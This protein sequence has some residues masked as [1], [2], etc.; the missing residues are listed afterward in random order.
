MGN[1]NSTISTDYTHVNNIEPDIDLLSVKCNYF[2]NRCNCSYRYGNHFVNCM[3]NK[4]KFNKINTVYDLITE[5]LGTRFL[6]VNVTIKNNNLEVNDCEH[7]VLYTTRKTYCQLDG[8]IHIQDHDEILYVACMII[9]LVILE[10]KLFDGKDVKCTFNQLLCAFEFTPI[11]LKLLNALK[12][13]VENEIIKLDKI[14]LSNET[15]VNEGLQ[16]LTNIGGLSM[17]ADERLIAIKTK[18]ATENAIKQSENYINM[19]KKNKDLIELF[20]IN[21]GIKE[22]KMLELK[23]SAPQIPIANLLTESDE[24]IPIAIPIASVSYV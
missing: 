21:L 8:R 13:I 7:K 14:I 24:S 3:Y 1:C 17:L 5:T 6:S 19:L 4:L 22:E 10:N 18:N 11:P 20:A 15:I 9:D 16:T 2:V 23:P 12:Q